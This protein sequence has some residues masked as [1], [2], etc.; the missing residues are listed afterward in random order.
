MNHWLKALSIT[1]YTRP[2]TEV[3]SSQLV[4]SWWG[5]LPQHLWW[6]IWTLGIT[7][8]PIWP[9]SALSD[10]NFASV[11]KHVSCKIHVTWTISISDWV[12]IAFRRSVQSFG[13][14]SC[15]MK[16]TDLYSWENKTGSWI[17]L[18]RWQFVQ[19]HAA[20]MWRFNNYNYRL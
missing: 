19:N 20:E 16:E 15:L 13:H 2:L 14:S 17:Y 11:L 6:P 5:Q 10:W 1:K 18:W 4:G 12:V 8:C 3:A 9:P 7:W